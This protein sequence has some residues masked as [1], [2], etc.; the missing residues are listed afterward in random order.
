MVEHRPRICRVA[1]SAALI[2]VLVACQP[3]SLTPGMVES[4][5]RSK[6]ADLE[7]WDDETVERL[8]IAT[9]LLVADHSL[10]V[11][12]GD[13]VLRRRTAACSAVPVS[14]DGYYVT[15]N[16]CFDSK[17]PLATVV[18]SDPDGSPKMLKKRPR[19]V[20]RAQPDTD[21]DIALFRLDFVPPVVFP[22][23]DVGVP[24][25]HGPVASA[26]WSVLIAATGSERLRKASSDMG[27]V[28][29][30]RILSVTSAD[31]PPAGS[32]F[33][34]VRHDTALAPGDSGGPIIDGD[35]ALIGI[36]VGGSFTGSPA[37]QPVSYAG[38]KA[39]TL[40]AGWLGAMIER[41]RSQHVV[42]PDAGVATR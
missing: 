42:D 29:D 4:L 24:R 38:A 5:V 13:V 36:N 34:I 18:W 20:W 35:G 19:I 30:G 22:L 39:V 26:G 1:A 32:V 10:R 28:W 23:T 3:G 21:V 37:N 11:R 33:R 12:G 17:M 7:H 6:S 40:D 41:D 16:H 25:L 2:G 15:A 8:R 27:W 14:A 9:A 31:D